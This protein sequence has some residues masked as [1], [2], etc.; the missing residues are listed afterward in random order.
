MYCYCKVVKYVQFTSNASVGLVH[1]NYMKG[2]TVFLSINT[3]KIL[4]K[5]QQYRF[6]K[7]LYI[8]KSY[9]Q[10]TCKRFEKYRAK[11][12]W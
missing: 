9:K 2:I 5:Q 8:G 11:M 3:T 6:C 7:M 4:Y 1:H 12:K 10:K